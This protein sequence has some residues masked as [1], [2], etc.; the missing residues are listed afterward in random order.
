MHIHFVPPSASQRR[1]KR[2]WLGGKEVR[3]VATESL[4]IAAQARCEGRK[5]AFRWFAV[6]GTASGPTGLKSGRIEQTGELALIVVADFLDRERVFALPQQQEL[7][8]D[9]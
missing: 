6:P 5:K 7:I 8:G 9:R 4:A 2:R 1:R 3:R